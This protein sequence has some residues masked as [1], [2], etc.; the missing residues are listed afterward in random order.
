MKKILL[1]MLAI[2]LMSVSYAQHLCAFDEIHEQKL[3]DDPEY[4][5]Q[6][7][8][9]EQQIRDYRR[10]HPELYVAGRTNEP[11][12]TIPVV[13]HVMHTGTE[14]GSLDNP[15]DQ[16][17]IDAVEYMNS[18]YS[19]AFSWVGKKAGLDVPGA[20]KDIGIRLV[21]AKRD[22]N[23]NPTN[24]IVRVNASSVSGYEVDG[25]RT[26]DRFPGVPELS[27]KNLSRWDPSRYYNIW[28]VNKINGADG[29]GGQFVAGYAY[30]PGSNS[31]VDGT[32]ALATSLRNDNQILT[33]ELGH[34]FNL[35]HPFQGSNVKVIQGT[36]QN[37][38]Q[39]VFECPVN[40]SCGDDGD[41]VC[42]TDPIAKNAIVV[43]NAEDV[44]FR[45]RDEVFPNNNTCTGTPYSPR[46][47]SNFMNYTN[48]FTLFTL[49]Q[50][51][52]MRDAMLLS[53]RASL[54]TSTGSIPPDQGTSV[55]PAKVNFNLASASVKETN[56]IPSG[57]FSY[58]DYT[59][60]I[61]IVSAPSSNA[62][63]TLTAGGTA[64][65]GVDY[66]I[67]TQGNL[68]T[69]SNTIIFP[70]GSS[71]SQN[72]VIRVNDDADVEQTENILLNFSVSGGGALKG[73]GTPSMTITIRDNDST[74]LAP[75]SVASFETGTY[76]ANLGQQATPFRGSKLKHRVQYL[77]S[78]SELLA[79]GIKPGQQIRGVSLF[80]TSKTSTAPYKGF[81]V[82]LGQTTFG[83]TTFRSVPSSVFTGEINT[84]PGENR[85]DFTTPF[86]WNGTSN[87]II[88]FCYENTGV[89]SND[90]IQ[91]QNNA[92][93]TGSPASCLADFTTETVEGCT[94]P[95]VSTS[96]T[97]AVIKF[98]ATV[99][100]NIVNS[101]VSPSPT[102]AWLGP[103][104]EVYFF[105][106]SGRILS[107]IKNLS[108][109]DYGCTNVEVDRAGTGTLPFWSTNTSNGLSQ[110]TF[111]VTPQNPNPNGSYEIALYYSNTEK[112][113]YESATGLNWSSVQMVK[114]GGAVSSITPAN[115][116]ASTVTVNNSAIKTTYG[117][118]HVV[119]AT[120]NNGFSGFAVGSPGI[121]TSVNDLNVL[122]GLH[123]YPNP[124]QK[125]L[126]L[127]FDQ[128]QRNVS[129]RLLSVD[130]RVLFLEN[131][132]G[133]LKNH[134]LSIEKVQP[135]YYLL[136]VITSEGRKTIPVIKQ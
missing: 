124:V 113:G 75:G 92:L 44:D 81:K 30:F 98:F 133:T 38:I 121:A 62:T 100:G 53:S 3:K 8:E 136:E 110:K 68:T 120:F 106:S 2:N 118:D 95:A 39:G 82:S 48:C 122:K 125:Q 107:R 29:T 86:T 130:G 21:L 69:P 12:Y 103:N 129:L 54:A 117:A 51:T 16:Q 112:T 37:I 111:K 55:C 5:R 61:S 66:N 11:I 40:A 78:P 114:T 116:Q 104:A 131:V 109:F 42:D 19:G 77:F 101:D 67:Y 7:R 4:A 83:L 50:R 96:T 13:V 90:V 56:E 33:H 135:G 22:P 108:S 99:P 31:S 1:L 63:V 123:I 79:A 127:Q 57:C 34:A 18:V 97:R 6:I 70:P 73:D 84:V 89:T 64:T 14:I 94:L 76:N 52:R 20:A 28:I 41:L 87:L 65:N 80:V 45:C 60:S 49:G 10:K 46:T 132:K 15:T 32:V 74:A 88:Q 36:P 71:I 58:K 47:E 25:I 59:Y 126:Y 102:Q 119:T 93:G 91:A 17:I 85:I 35:F 115:Q 105:N 128:T 23:C 9:N 26:S 43:N 27:I 134:I 24:G 72:F